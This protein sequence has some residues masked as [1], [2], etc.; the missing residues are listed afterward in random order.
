MTKPFC[1]KCLLEDMD[2]DEINQSILDYIKEIPEHK[3]VDENTYQKRLEI[4]RS[5]ESLVNG[6]CAKCGCYVELRA[7]KTQMYCASEDKKW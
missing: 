1:K 6:M 5:C 3:R 7:L 4:C 2:F